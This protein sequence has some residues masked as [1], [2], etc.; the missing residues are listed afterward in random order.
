MQVALGNSPADLVIL[1]GQVVNVFSREIY[2]GGIAI[3]GAKI[4]AVGDVEYAVG[5]ETKVIDAGGRFLTPGLVDGHVH[6]ESSTL[7]ITRFAGLALRHGTTS[8]MSDLH[9]VAVVGGLSA[10][11]EVLNEGNRLPFKVYFVVPS[12][13]PFSP[14]FETTGGVIGP[15]E[16]ATAARFP[17]SVGLSE[18]V[19]TFA[20]NEEARLWKAMDIIRSAGQTLHGHCPFTKGA[21]LSAFASLGIRTDHESFDFDDGIQRLRAGIHL[22]I[23]HGSA[24]ESIPDLIRIVTEKGLDSRHISIITDDYLAEDLLSK[25][26]MD[27]I[28]RKLIKHGVDP[29]TAIQMTSLNAAE[30]YRVDHEIGV[31]APG[32]EADILLV[33]DLEDFNVH[34]VIS[35]GILVAE[36][37]QTIGAFPEPSP[38]PAQMNSVHVARP[39]TPADLEQAVGKAAGQDKVRVNT[40][41]IPPEIPVPDLGI[42]EVNVQNGIP[43]P[44]P[45]ND[46]AVICVV[47]RHKATGNIAVA[48]AKGFHL[49]K[50]AMASSVAHDHHKIIAIGTNYHDLARSVN[51]VIELQGG[52][53]VACDG[54]VTAEVPLPIL[55]LMSLAPAEEVCQQANRLTTAAREIGCDLRWP[56]MFLSF[57]SCSSGPGYSITD[58]G[59][60]DGYHQRFIPVIA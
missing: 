13:V 7:N 35:R 6:V 46:M 29:V 16:V 26:Y 15:D 57:V 60:L 36:N 9:E 38:S 2:P 59:F 1:N 37:E 20:L 56:L 53:V 41:V 24:A 43:Q 51:R 12:H 14:G 10:L 44:Q 22:Q 4:A 50:G 48:F 32:R 27:A 55:G 11:Q 58:K 21:Q 3:R 45:E 34:Q 31:L 54:V 42:F 30:A 39:I 8:I 5:K 25:G 28:V 23:R 33:D 49:K 17:R 40:L 19:V 47:E 18:V 52:Q